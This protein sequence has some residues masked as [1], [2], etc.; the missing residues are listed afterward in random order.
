MS[1]TTIGIWAKDGVVLAVEK[2]VQ[3][4]LLVRGSNKRIQSAD[5]HVAVPTAEFLADG[6]HLVTRI[7]E[8]AQQ[9]RDLIIRFSFSNTSQ[10]SA[11]SI[12]DLSNPI[13]TSS[14]DLADPSAMA[15]APSGGSTDPS[16]GLVAS[17]NDTTPIDD[18]SPTVA[19]DWRVRLDAIWKIYWVAVR[20]L[21]GIPCPPLDQILGDSL[22]RVLPGPEGHELI[23]IQGPLFQNLSNLGMHYE[24][25]VFEEGISTSEIEMMGPSH[26][27]EKKVKHPYSPPESTTPTA[28][29]PKRQHRRRGKGRNADDVV[30]KPSTPK[31]SEPLSDDDDTD[32]LE[33]EWVGDATGRLHALIDTMKTDQHLPEHSWVLVDAEES[34][35]PTGAIEFDETFFG[36]KTY[37]ARAF[38]KGQVRLG[39]AATSG[40]A[41]F[42]VGREK[43]KRLKFEV[44]VPT[45]EVQFLDEHG[46]TLTPNVREGRK[47]DGE[48]VREVSR[49]PGLRHNYGEAKTPAGATVTSD[50]LLA[51]WA[52]VRPGV[53][54]TEYQFANVTVTPMNV[55]E[56]V[57]VQNSTAEG[58]AFVEPFLH[59]A[60]FTSDGDHIETESFIGHRQVVG[61][62]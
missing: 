13:A 7:R 42:E 62:E 14:S 4:K 25:R 40:G 28:P 50:E 8:E 19:M 38:V 59:V 22:M 12:T 32:D 23:R 21:A 24:F 58:L 57:F 11:K 26:K 54:Q 2:P 10:T 44:V 61:M 36:S 35:I 47:E 17:L 33:H 29:A 31:R 48:G 16:A 30:V 43:V 34:E 6:H 51:K 20:P 5:S 1:R 39:V 3:S 37:V 55:V 52:V 41:E 56:K 60:T 46:K 49:V 27:R 18:A 53:G 9:H 45:R 15:D